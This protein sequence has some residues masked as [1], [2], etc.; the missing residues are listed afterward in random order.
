MGSS[1]P[2]SGM[3]I[4]SAAVFD[5]RGVLG[6]ATVIALANPAGAVGSTTPGIT[7]RL[8]FSTPRCHRSWRS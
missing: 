8:A 1:S 3:A 7:P 4:R 5:R 2:R 6:T